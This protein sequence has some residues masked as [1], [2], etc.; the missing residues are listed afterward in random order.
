M[1]LDQLI[2]QQESFNFI[3]QNNPVYTANSSDKLPRLGLLV[4]T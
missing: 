4:G 1:L 3:V 2:L